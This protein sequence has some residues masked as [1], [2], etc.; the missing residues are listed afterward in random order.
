[1]K[2]LICCA[3][4]LLSL[5]GPAQIKFGVQAGY[6]DVNLSKFGP[7]KNE[8][9]PEDHYSSVNS[10]HAGVL[11]EIPLSQHWSL[12]P[13]LLYYGNG[14]RIT[15]SLASPG[16]NF[17]EDA[18]I[19]IYYL[20]LP[21]NMIYTIKAGRLFHAFIGAGFYVARGLSGT[22]KGYS[23][24]SNVGVTGREPV[25]IKIDF[26]NSGPP[27]SS[28][29]TL[30]IN[31]YDAG[32]SFLAGLEWQKFQLIPSVSEGFLNA[33]TGYDYNLRNLSFSVSLTYRL[34]TIL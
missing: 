4:C 24:F 10:F 20:R 23:L 13:A 17:Y 12:A 3:M 11:T 34:F 33:Y 5:S 15:S 18:A 30:Q 6:N 32:Y 21:V 26:T 28:S 8:G 1:M 27:P 29:G 2:T 9:G 16:G 14:A 22:S 31:P 25:D 7:F 19:R